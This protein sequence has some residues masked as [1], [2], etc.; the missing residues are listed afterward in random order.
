MWIKI[1]NKYT[2][3]GDSVE[4]GRGFPHVRNRSQRKGA[5]GDVS[6]Q[7]VYEPGT[8]GVDGS[9][10]NRVAAAPIRGCRITQAAGGRGGAARGVEENLPHP[11]ALVRTGRPLRRLGGKRLA[12]SQTRD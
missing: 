12:S 4:C 9:R 7:A 5:Q 11:G 8:V 10:W 3:R 1:V 6:P 2:Y